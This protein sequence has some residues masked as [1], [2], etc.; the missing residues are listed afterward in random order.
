M[1]NYLNI[2]AALLLCAT[3]LSSCKERSE[4]ELEQAV[5]SF[6]NSVGDAL[7]DALQSG[8]GSATA[9]NNDIVVFLQI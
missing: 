5:G 4:G 2:F 9:E 6:V 3:L 1:K 8:T 7:E